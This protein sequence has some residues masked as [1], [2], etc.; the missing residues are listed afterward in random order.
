MNHFSK[1]LH[2]LLGPPNRRTVCPRVPQEFCEA[3]RDEKLPTQF[4]EDG[5]LAVL[6]NKGSRQLKPLVVKQGDQLKQ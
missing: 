1:A 6:L 3:T 2:S 5:R 4:L